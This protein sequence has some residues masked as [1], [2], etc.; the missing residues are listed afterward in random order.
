MLDTYLSLV[1]QKDADA[2]RQG[3]LTALEEIRVDY[4]LQSSNQNGQAI[5]TIRV[6][7]HQD[8]MPYI[9]LGVHYDGVGGGE[10]ANKNAAAVAITLGILRVFYF[11]R[12]TKARP[13]PLEF[14]FFDGHHQDMAGSHAYAAQVD[15]QQIHMMINLDMCGVGDTVLVASGAHVTGS[16]AEKA[17]R[18]LET[19]PYYPTMRMM[20]LL[21]PGDHLPFEAKK[22]P[23]VT[24]SIVPEEDI[25]PMVGLAVA[26]HNEEQVAVLPSIYEVVHNPALDTVAHVQVDAMRQVMLIVNALISNLLTLMPDGIDWK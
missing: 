11:I 16:A 8:E 15:T 13:L 9:L 23:T 25:V 7:M 20:A 12:R 6:P 1:A 5:E 19:S 2:R 21:P 14:V 4:T 10:G 17:V 3:V 26:L 24:I 22:V 18:R